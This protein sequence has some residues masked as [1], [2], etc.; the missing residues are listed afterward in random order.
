MRLRHGHDQQFRALKHEGDGEFHRYGNLSGGK[1]GPYGN[2]PFDKYIYM[3]LLLFVVFLGFLPKILRVC[4][5]APPRPRRWWEIGDDNDGDDDEEEVPELSEEERKELVEKSLSATIVVAHSRSVCETR[6]TRS[7][8]AD[9]DGS[10]TT[11]DDS[12]A[13][14]PEAS[15]NTSTLQPCHICLERFQVGDEVSWSNVSKCGHTFHKAC[16]EEWM[17]KH[18]D[19][20]CCR[21][22][23]L[24]LPRTDSATGSTVEQVVNH[25]GSESESA[26]ENEGGAGGAGE[27]GGEKQERRDSETATST[28]TGTSRNHSDNKGG[29]SRREEAFCFCAEHGLQQLRS[30]STLSMVKAM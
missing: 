5:C 22:V 13:E 28:C 30:A 15:P 20:P 18:E 24:R 1:D 2:E 26:Y 4:G 11:L 10:S 7:S 19:C 16:I 14:D 6:P 3:A 27:G 29:N 9:D 25:D 12:S 8:S 23:T 21:A 17:V